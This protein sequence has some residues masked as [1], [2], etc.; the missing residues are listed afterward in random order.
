[1]SQQVGRVD[2]L[3]LHEEDDRYLVVVTRDGDRVFRARLELK[4][5]D[6]GPRPGRFRIVRGSETEP[7][8]PDEFVELA[9]RARRIRISEQTSRA[10]RAELEAMLDGYQLD[11]LTVRTC[12]Y[13]A[14]AGRYS[15]IT[16]DTAIAADRDHICP[17]CARR[18]LERELSYVGGLTAAAKDRLEELLL[19]VQ[20]LDRIT[21]LLQGELDPELTKFDEMGATVEDV[22]PVPTAD[23]DLHPALQSRTEDR[24]ETLLPVQSLSVRNGLFDGRD[25]LVVS[26]TATGKTLVGE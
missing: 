25:Q 6:A 20:D 4:A 1:M 23:L 11:A 18:E 10:G 15:P 7:R 12:R 3:F 22:D 13:C 2:T 5:T 19:D 24:F 16:E 8:D 17:D 26:A 9:R 21:D 14:G